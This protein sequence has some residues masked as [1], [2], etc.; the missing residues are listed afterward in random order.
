M[1]GGLSLVYVVCL[2]DGRKMTPLPLLVRHEEFDAKVKPDEVQQEQHEHSRR[3]C[4][5]G[6]FPKRPRRSGKLLRLLRC[7]R[8]VDAVEHWERDQEVDPIERGAQ[9]ER[10]VP[11][12]EGVVR[13][14]ADGDGL[15]K[16]RSVRHACDHRPLEQSSTR[17]CL[18]RCADPTEDRIAQGVV[19][20][21]VSVCHQVKADRD[22]VQAVRIKGVPSLEDAVEVVRVPIVPN[23][24]EYSDPYVRLRDVPLPPLQFAIC[25]AGPDVRED[26]VQ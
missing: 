17:V 6:R 14:G 16:G 5:L 20:H 23:E 4:V 12:P 26:E 11:V 1:Q 22:V 7:L 2:L 24:A 25:R 18:E 13:E 8:F 3:E 15:A 21:E 10:I 19:E 9:G